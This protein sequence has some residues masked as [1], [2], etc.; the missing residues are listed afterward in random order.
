MSP[1]RA[2]IAT[3]AAV[4]LL[5]G[6]AEGAFPGANG[7]IASAR[8]SPADIYAIN[9]DGSGGTALTGGTGSARNPA[10]SPDGTKITFDRNADIYVMN[11]DGSNLTRLTTDPA[12]DR[13]PSWSPDGSQLA[14][15]SNRAGSV[16][17]WKMNVDGSGQ[18]RLTT[19]PA[20]DRDPAWS[21][22]GTKIAFSS[23]RENYV[24]DDPESFPDCVPSPT[25]RIFTIDP[26]GGNTTRHTGTQPYF[27]CELQGADHAA[28]DWSPAGDQIAY[29]EYE[30]DN[31]VEEVYFVRIR[32]TA[33][34][35]VFSAPDYNSSFG[36]PPEVGLAF[37]PDGRQIVFQLTRT[38][39][40]YERGVGTRTLTGCCYV[41]PSWQP[42]PV[43]AYPRP[44]GASPIYLSLVPAYARC[45]AP[46]TQH[47]AP[48]SSNSCTLP[49]QASSALTFGTPDANGRQ[50]NGVGFAVLTTKADNLA[51]PSD[52]S[53]VK[54]QVSVTDVRQAN[55]LSDHTGQLEA[56][57]V[58]RITDRDNIP[59]PGGPGAGT[60][61]GIPFP[62]TVPCTPTA[63][64]NIGST[65]ATVTTAEAVLPGSLT[66]G[67]RAVWE[68]ARFDV[69][70]GTSA[71]FLTQGLFIP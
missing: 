33:W 6:T 26:N 15:E 22:D 8:L 69:Y 31:C 24:C 1:T 64:T 12:A 20:T 14:F 4:L 44:R 25:F 59:S 35:S 30:L 52:E 27:S 65:C 54:L 41:E 2:A 9:P 29:V 21:P 43:N 51:T 23:D 68:L 55:D 46:N 62:Y 18:V 53:D 47:G 5:R 32:T 71:P 45:T 67:R 60:S 17:L 28:P 37:S 63:A 61:V 49:A 7:K 48:L 16:D 19:D 10:W 66:G 57:P 38:L 40:I 3:C 58:I 36:F 39:R 34:H 13:D 42:L 56:R 11:A 50:A 70:D